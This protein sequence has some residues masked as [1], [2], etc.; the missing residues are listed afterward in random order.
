MAYRS[1]T[2][3]AQG[4]ALKTIIGIPYALDSRE[5]VVIVARDG[6]EHTIMPSSDPAGN[7]R[8]GHE[9]RN[10]LPWGGGTTIELAVPGGDCP[11]EEEGYHYVG[12]DFDPLHWV[13]SFALFNPHLTASYQASYQAS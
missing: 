1:P 2:R 13:R 10:G 7:V 8:I 9:A 11:S 4:N 12:Q 5:P 3:G 6:V